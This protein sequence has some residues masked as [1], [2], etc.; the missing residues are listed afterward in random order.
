MT[1]APA[2][3]MVLAAGRGERMRPL[4]LVVPKPALPLPE[5]PVV[6]SA[7]RLAVASGAPR[8]VA[9]TWHL[10]GRMERA[11]AEVK[12]PVGLPS[13]S[14]EPALMGTGGGLALAR[15]RGLLGDA[16]PVL[17]ANGDC[18]LELDLGPVT[19]R[20]AA[21]RDL[22]TLALLPHPD[23]GRWSRV[24]VD[25]DGTVTAIRPPGK[26]A[27]GEAALLYPGVM[28]VAREGLDALTSAPGGV[29]DQLWWPAL[30]AGRLGGA[31]VGGRWRE[32]GTPDDYRDLVL[33]RVEAR[34]WL[35]PTARVDP[36]ATIRSS[37]IGS[38]CQVAAAAQVLR[39]VLLEGAVVGSGAVVEDSILVGAVRVA[40]GEN[41]DGDMLV[42]SP[43]SS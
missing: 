17:V 36:A 16:G 3:A 34:S 41:C 35:H 24:A 11:L 27:E 9:N 31:V 22:V 1:G 38:D 43:E 8:V 15:D 28:M 29:D 25:R 19:T 14:R 18:V 33:D 23:P 42:S 40:D 2:A 4:S 39:S 6:A 5:G 12:L 10:A 13:V 20:H 30:R 32:V 7:L 37:F 21:S 26:V